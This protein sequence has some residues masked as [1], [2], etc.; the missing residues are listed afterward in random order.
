LETINTITIVSRVFRQVLPPS[1]S[2]THTHSPTHNRIALAY[3]NPCRTHG[4]HGDGG[5]KSHCEFRSD[6]NNNNARCSFCAPDE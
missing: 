6:D 4:D 1:N 3:T 2:P 5:T